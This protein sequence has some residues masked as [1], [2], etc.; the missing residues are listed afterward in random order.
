MK[1]DAKDTHDCS[2]VVVPVKVY[3]SW[4]KEEDAHMY[5]YCEAAIK[6]DIRDGFTVIKE[7]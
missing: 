1:C 6:E 5:N 4:I 3:G 7:V 2:G